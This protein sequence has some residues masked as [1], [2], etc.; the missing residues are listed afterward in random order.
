MCSFIAWLGLGLG[1]GFGLGLGLG[2]G[3]AIVT[4][5]YLLLSRVKSTI[6]WLG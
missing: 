2:L 1:L 6:T 5:P 3:L 4:L